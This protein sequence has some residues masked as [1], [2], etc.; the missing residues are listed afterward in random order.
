[1]TLAALILGVLLAYYFTY[2]FNLVAGNLYLSDYDEAR[3]L[4][5]L[6]GRKKAYLTGLLG[7]P[8]RMAVTALLVETFSLAVSSV[9]LFMIGHMVGPTGLYGYGLGA[10]FILVGW[11]IHLTIAEVLA[12]NVRQERAL[13]RLT[14]RYLIIR[15]VS[16]IFAPFVG[17]MIRRKE[18]LFGNEEY[19]EKKEEI[20]E[21][22]IESLAESA[23]IDEPLMERSERQMIEN[24]FELGETEVREVMV[25][26]IEIISI[27]V[28]TSFAE[29]R[30]IAADS[31]YS[32]LPLY[33]DDIDNIKGIIFLKDLFNAGPI[34]EAGFDLVKLAR[35]PYF[36]PESKKLSTL[37]EDFR[38][39][40]SHIAIVVD[41]FGGTAGL[42]TL[43]DLLE[44][45]VGDIQDEH[46][47][48][49]ADIVKINDNTYMVAANISMEDLSDTLELALEEK[50]F[51]TVGGYIYDLVGSLP[52]VG[53]RIDVDGISF[54]V[55][56]IRGQRIEKVRLILDPD[57]EGSSSD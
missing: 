31:G 32:R 53:K 13:K 17:S 24:I 51:E 39:Q 20:V 3:L 27:E 42:V 16:A 29:V 45:I 30:Q 23:G 12:P 21:R 25:P 33:Q 2:L 19:E 14:G 37:L 38:L 15:L 22:A 5:S 57:W 11:G 26:R 4:T 36:V 28:G 56:K 40:R 46:D 35:A 1:M 6:K 18:K 54:V 43:E 52:E 48:E 44:I 50:D 47:A 41:E 9:L 34:D 55:E 8:K 10:L 49:E 7:N